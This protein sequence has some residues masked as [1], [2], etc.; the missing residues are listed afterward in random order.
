[1]KALSSI[2]TGRMLLILTALSFGSIASTSSALAGAGDLDPDFGDG[3]IVTTDFMGNLDAAKAVIALENGKIIA[4]GKTC[5]STHCDFALTRYNAN[6]ERD[7]TCGANGWVT[8]DFGGTNDSASTDD[9]ANAATVDDDGYIIVVGSAAT[10]DTSELETVFTFAIARYHEDG[11]LDRRFGGFGDDKPGR[12]TTSFPLGTFAEAEAVAVWDESG[13]FVVVGAAAKGFVEVEGA[14]ELDQ[15]DFA[16]ARY[17]KDGYLDYSF[18]VDGLV[19]TGL[20]PPTSY[21][22]A[23]DVVLQGDKIIAAGFTQV[24]VHGEPDFLLVRFNA[25]GSLDTGFGSGG[26]VTTD[27]FGDSADVVEAIALQGDKIVA[28]GST[29]HPKKDKEEDFALARYHHNGKLDGTFGR[30]GMVVTDFGISAFDLAAD[31]AVTDDGIL[32]IGAA[33]ETIVIDDTDPDNPIEV[34]LEGLALARYTFKG[35]LDAS[36]GDGGIVTTNFVDVDC[37]DVNIHA[38]VEAVAIKDGRIIVAGS[39]ANTGESVTTVEPPSCAPDDPS[40]DF[41]LAVYDAWD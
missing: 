38:G 2:C 13:T 26:M 25:D 3:G 14:V 32:V 39:I 18:G 10:V 8:T 31:V 28:A 7:R 15:P 5:N 9:S 20:T 35:K 23:T 4:V 41:L 34:D 37:P 29:V 40:S 27:F 30:G 24:D 19:T 33:G 17:D 16:L 21:D 36:F 6:G 22:E 12:V 1:M 11:R